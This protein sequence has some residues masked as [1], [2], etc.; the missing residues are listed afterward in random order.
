MNFAEFKIATEGMVSGNRVVVMAY[1]GALT[2]KFNAII[3]F[4]DEGLC[5]LCSNKKDFDGYREGNL[6]YGMGYSWA[7][8]SDG[9]V[10]QIGSIQLLNSV[11]PDCIRLPLKYDP[12]SQFILTAD[13]QPIL[14]MRGHGLF[15]A[16]GVKPNELQ[17]K[18]GVT[19]VDV[20]N[21]TFS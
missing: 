18:L 10:S 13:D 15:V 21:E 20:L 2:R 3:S 11:L 7:C 9:D 19:F 8:R 14:Q 1:C 17:D 4:N 5:F 12:E 16:N 6:L